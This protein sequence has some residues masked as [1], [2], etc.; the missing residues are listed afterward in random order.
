M[1]TRTLRRKSRL[2]SFPCT[3]TTP[4][5]SSSLRDRLNSTKTSSRTL[6]TRSTLVM[7]VSHWATRPLPAP[8]SPSSLLMSQSPHPRQHSRAS[9]SRRSLSNLTRHQR[10]HLMCLLLPI[11][12]SLTC[13]TTLSSSPTQR[14]P[15]SKCS[16]SRASTSSPLK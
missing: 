13:A 11:S 15:T 4:S 10:P 3:W 7:I 14:S 1:Q 8:S 2:L 9:A 12:Q 5:K 6:Q 16:T